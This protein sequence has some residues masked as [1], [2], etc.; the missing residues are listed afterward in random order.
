MAIACGLGPY[1]VPEARQGMMLTG[2]A[3]FAVARAAP[4]LLR[5]AIRPLLRDLR[6]DPERTMRRLFAGL[7][8]ADRR[9]LAAPG[10]LRLFAASA[11][12]AL[13]QGARPF[14]EEAALYARPWGFRLEDVTLDVRL[15]QGELDVNVPPA[16]ARYQEARLPRCT[17][18][19]YPRD[20]HYSL[21]YEHLEEILGQLVEDEP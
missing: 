12:E 3:L 21:V 4:W 14:A 19:Y 16:M 6:R 20:G 5:L 2:R 15:Y 13:R 17:A 7:P 18:K 9:V 1:D 11:S 8:D 10:R